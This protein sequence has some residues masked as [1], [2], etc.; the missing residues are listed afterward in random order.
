MSKNQQKSTYLPEVNKETG[1][2]PIQEQTAI[3]LASGETIT[4]VAEQLSLNRGTI[5]KWQKQIAFNCFFNRQCADSKSNLIIGL[6]GL[7]HEALNTIKD[8]LHSDNEATRLKAAMWLTDKINNIT[9]GQTDVIAAVK[10]ECTKSALDWDL[11]KDEFNERQYKEKL[12][13]LGVVDD[14]LQ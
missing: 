7:A 9:V 3:L 8:C 10:K 14:E 5:Y 4:A 13:E 2:T 12:K 6:F 11:G 1:L